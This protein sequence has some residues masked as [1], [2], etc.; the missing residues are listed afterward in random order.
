M[1]GQGSDKAGA[2]SGSALHIIRNLRVG[3]VS[4]AL[5]IS[6]T[7]GV[8]AWR[9]WH[10]EKA[11]EQLYL[12][13]LVEITGKSLDA[14][15][16]NHARSLHQLGADIMAA[17]SP[18]VSRRT[19]ELLKHL[20][21][22]NPDFLH[23]TVVLPDGR[24][25]VSDNVDA[26]APLP[27]LAANESFQLALR[28]IE[29]GDEFNIGRA[30]MAG[31]DGVWA[32]PLR[33]GVR[34]GQGSLRF[35]LS[36][37]LPLTRQQNFWQ[38]V[39]L[40][41]ESALGLLRDDGYM[42]SRYPT[43]KAIDYNEAYGKPRTG[44]LRE[45]LLEN[46]FPQR[47]ATEG[48]NSVAKADYLFSFHRLSSYPLTVFVST[49]LSNIQDKWLRQAQFSFLLL[50]T[51]LVGGYLVYRR[52]IR[53]QLAWEMEHKAHEGRIRFLAQHD[54]L[55]GLPNRLLAED[56]LQQA[57]ATPAGST[58]RWRCCSSISTTSRASTIRWDTAWAM[59]CSRK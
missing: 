53:Y 54:P 57:L 49:P 45:F 41:A 2:A 37:L 33:L 26:G 13:S 1:S 19:H 15:F 44:Q 50:L 47:G 46:H 11:H 28:D 38:D 12:S 43:P 55:T 42:I 21:D 36:A 32:I 31:R 56:R 25:M 17:D 14:Y 34:D 58:P 29:A 20:K 7:G 10:T 52:A 5:L 59:P 30:V 48:Y 39:P 27:H 6:V 22:G 3:F 16:G 9:S 51:L 24:V 40:P 23:V 4:M 8:L 35:I 18:L